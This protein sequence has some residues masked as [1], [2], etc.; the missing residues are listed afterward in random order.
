MH[1][2]TLDGRPENHEGDNSS[3]DSE[4]VEERVS[5][6]RTLPSRA[7]SISD[8]TIFKYCLGGLTDRAVL[9]KEVAISAS[10]DELLKFAQEVSV[11][12]G[13]SHHG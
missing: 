12:S 7:Y 1:R 3:T 6:F 11:Y 5:N 13:C 10:E 2:S 9:L 8:E 4:N